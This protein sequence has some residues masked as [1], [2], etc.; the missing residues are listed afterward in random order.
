MMMLVDQIGMN[1]I[2]EILQD[3]DSFLASDEKEK[4]WALLHQL[5]TKIKDALNASFEKQKQLIEQ[6]LYKLQQK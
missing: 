6:E 5:I 3:I 1:E 2:L 4:A